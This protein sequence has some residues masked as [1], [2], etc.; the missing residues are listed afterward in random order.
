MNLPDRFIIGLGGG[1]F[2]VWALSVIA[3]IVANALDGSYHTP[4][5]LHGMMGTIV[6]AVFTEARMRARRRALDQEDQ[7]DA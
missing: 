3:E 4:L 1:V 6:G 2:A 5:P 7:P